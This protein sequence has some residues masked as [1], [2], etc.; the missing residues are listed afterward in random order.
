MK[1]VYIVTDQASCLHHSLEA[2]VLEA[3]R[4]GV[5]LVQLREKPLTPEVFWKKLWP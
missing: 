2:V 4:A 3:A 5:C 1:G